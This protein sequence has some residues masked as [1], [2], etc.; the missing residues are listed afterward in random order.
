MRPETFRYYVPALLTEALYTGEGDA[1]DLAVSALSPCC[2]ALYSE[3]SDSHLRTMQSAFTEAQYRA[4]ADFLGLAFDRGT[5]YAQHHAARTLRWGWNQFNTP[6]LQAAQAYY[7]ELSSYSYPESENPTIADL[8]REIRTAFALTPYPGD[9]ALCESYGEEPAEIAL[10]LRG[11]PWQAAHPTL[12]ARCDSALSFLSD[13]GFRYFLPAF[14]LA[15]L[16]A[17][18]IG[19]EGNANPVYRFL[20]CYT[21]PGREH[22]RRNAEGP[23]NLQS[24]C[25]LYGASWS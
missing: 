13:A 20:L 6:A 16:Q 15:D 14:L 25:E 18:E 17:N 22:R 4:V 12:L 23:E 11:V 24:R 1:I 2:E 9:D 3:G 8:C 7:R 5:G 10:D 19:Y 21:R